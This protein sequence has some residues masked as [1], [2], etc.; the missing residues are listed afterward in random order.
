MTPESVVRKQNN[1]VAVG[2]K[3]QGHIQRL[4]GVQGQNVSPDMGAWR[5]VFCS[6]IGDC[7]IENNR[8]RID[9]I[10]VCLDQFLGFIS[11]SHYCF[12]DAVL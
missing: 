6:R 5:S 1:L 8:F 4:S 9:F 11:E 3:S 12:V 10:Q 2:K 7:S